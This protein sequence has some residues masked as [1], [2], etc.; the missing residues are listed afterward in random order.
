VP[1]VRLD[2]GLDRKTTALA[3]SALAMASADIV[4]MQAL[5]SGQAIESEMVKLGM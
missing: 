3:I 1:V 5:S 2:T 4:L